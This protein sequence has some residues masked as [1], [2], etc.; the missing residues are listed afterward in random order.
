MSY[1]RLEIVSLH[2]LL[3]RSINLVQLTMTAPLN[4]YLEFR[5]LVQHAMR[6][7]QCSSIRASS[8]SNLCVA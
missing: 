4:R 6:N 7:A 3:E 5:R 1:A 2:R 8:E